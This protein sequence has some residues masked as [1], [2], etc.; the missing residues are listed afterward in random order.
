M[1]AVTPTNWW[2]LIPGFVLLSLGLLSG[3]GDWAPLLAARWGGSLFLGGISLSFWAIY[4]ARR[5]FWWAIIPAGVL[6]TLAVVAG[7]NP[8]ASG[9]FAGF[10]FF[11]GIALTFGL[12]YLAPPAPARRRW[13]IIPAAA[14]LAIGVLTI[15]TLPS[16]FN[17][18]WPIAI[19]ISGLYLVYHALR[20]TATGQPASRPDDTPAPH[21]P[22][23]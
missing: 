15:V 22:K 21:A 13:A 18:L 8:I 16:M 17:L 1:F 10:V 4:L 9:A 11:M 2:A 6:L 12:M 19:I 23:V 20:Q 5:A 14:A 3:L 7:L